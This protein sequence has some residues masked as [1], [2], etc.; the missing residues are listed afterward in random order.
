MDSG[1]SKRMS[2]AL[3]E[4]LPKAA[5]LAP[6]KNCDEAT[7]IDLSN[8]PNEALRG[9]LQEFFTTV[10]EDKLTSEVCQQSH[11]Q[12]HTNTTLDF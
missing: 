12:A 11:R 10:V 5:A 2:Q 1:L 8:A 3:Q 9:E 4:L 6:P 7:A